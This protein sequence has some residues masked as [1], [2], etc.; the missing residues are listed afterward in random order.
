MRTARQKAVTRRNIAYGLFAFAGLSVLL[1][2][3]GV[4]PLDLSRAPTLSA[5]YGLKLAYYVW[6]AIPF[7]IGFIFWGSSKEKFLEAEAEEKLAA[8]REK[9]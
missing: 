5:A 2:L 4:T 1:K 6:P 3:T 8:E 9:D 7:V